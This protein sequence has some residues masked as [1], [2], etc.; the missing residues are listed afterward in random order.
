MENKCKTV[1]GLQELTEVR[2]NALEKITD[3]RFASSQMALRLGAKETER[4][5]DLLNGE[6]ERLRLI[7][8][9]YLPREV[10]DANYREQNKEISEL[11]DFKANSQ[12]RQA[13]LSVLVSAGISVL[14]ILMAHLL[15]Y[16]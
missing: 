5:L 6:A 10:Y 15:K 3:E 1:G 14:M 9:T 13:T 7:Q 8:A 16:I 11:R 12:G 4:R 2:I